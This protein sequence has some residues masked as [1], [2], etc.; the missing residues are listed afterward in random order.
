MTSPIQ[1]AAIVPKTAPA[2]ATFQITAE[3]PDGSIEPLLWLQP[4]KP[5]YAH[6]FWFRQPVLLPK[7][8][9]IRGIPG[10]AEIQLVGPA[11]IRKP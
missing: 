9:V 6:E 2:G 11:L 7:G 5:E 10:G 1:A 4:F 8:T 3:K